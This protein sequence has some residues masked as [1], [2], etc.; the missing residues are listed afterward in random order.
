MSLCGKPKQA[1][2]LTSRNSAERER[3]RERDFFDGTAGA[4]Q[5]PANEMLTMQLVRPVLEYGAI[6]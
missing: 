3:E 1:Q 2:Q 4:A 5:Q 6:I